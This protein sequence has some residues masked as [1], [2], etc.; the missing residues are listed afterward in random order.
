[1][2]TIKSWSGS[3]PHAREV[4]ALD[5]LRK[6]LPSNWFGYANVFVK[7]P[8]SDTG[9]EVDLI[10]ISDDRILMIDVKD[11]VGKISYNRG[12]W[13]QEVSDRKQRTM[14]RDPVLKLIDA[15]NALI[16]SMR[17]ARIN[18][19]PF[20][21]KAVVFARSTTDFSE[22]AEIHKKG[23][24]GRVLDV[25]T[26][27]SNSKNTRRLD[28]VI[29]KPAFKSAPT[30][31]TN[32][33][34]DLYRKLKGFFQ[35][36]RHF[37]VAE[38][39]YSAYRAKNDEVFST[40]LWAHYEATSKDAHD[41]LAL[42]RRWNFDAEVGVT[43]VD[44]DRDTLV[45]R[46]NNIQAFLRS[47][48]TGRDTPLLAFKESSNTGGALRW[49]LF[50][51]HPDN[52]VLQR[53][54]PRTRSEVSNHTRIALLEALMEAGSSLAAAEVAHRDIGEHSVWLDLERQ[55][56]SLSNLVTAR[57]PETKTT[58]RNLAWL[59]HSRLVDP[60]TEDS[61]EA[62]A[63]DPFRADV[64]AFAYA[65]LK[66]LLG[67]LAKNELDDEC[68][69]YAV[70]EEAK[71]EAGIGPALDSWF[72][73][74]L[75]ANPRERFD[76][77]IEAHSALL[78][79][80]LQDRED[81]PID[82]LEP[83]R[84]QEPCM[85]AYPI[86]ESLSTTR[87]GVTE[88]RS[89]L[90]SGAMLRARLWNVSNAQD[91][92]SAILDFV[93]RG[94]SLSVLPPTIAPRIV[95]CS[96][97]AYG[98]FLC[99]EETIGDRL[100]DC[101][102]YIRDLDQDGLVDLCR[103][104]AKAVL[105]AHDLDLAHGDLSPSNLLFA[106]QSGG[107]DSED[108]DVAVRIIDWLD[109][110]TNEAGPRETVAY[111]GDEPDPMQR[112]RRALGRIIL[113]LVKNCAA[114]SDIIEAAEIFAAE[115]PQDAGLSWRE[116]SLLDVDELLSTKI[117]EEARIAV[118]IKDMLNGQIISPEDGGYR[119]LFDKIDGSTGRDPSARSVKI[120]GLNAVV[121][122]SF[123]ATTKNFR[124]AQSRR[125]SNRLEQFASRKGHRIELTLVSDASANSNCWNF[126]RELPGFDEMFPESPDLQ[127]RRRRPIL[128][129]SSRKEPEVQ[130]QS[131]E[132]AMPSPLR[133]WDAMLDAEATTWPSATAL[134]EAKRMASRP[135]VY[136]VEVD[137]A[138][139]PNLLEPGLLVTANDRTVAKLEK[140]R[141][142][143]GVIEIVSDRGPPS[144]IKPNVPMEFI[145]IG[146]RSNIRRRQTALRKI[147]DA[148]KIVS[149]ERYFSD[150]A[151]ATLGESLELGREPLDYS[152][153]EP[154]SRALTKLWQRGPV[155]FLQGPPGTGKTMFIAAFIHHALTHGGAKNV[156]LT[157]QTHEA[158]DGAAARLLELFQNRGEE[159]DLIRIASNAERID[160]ALRNAHAAAL[161]ERV[162]QRF[163]AERAERVVALATP[164]GIEPEFVRECSK[165]LR[166][167]VA[168]AETVEALKSQIEGSGVAE[169]AE[170]EMLKRMKGVLE[171]QCASYG[172][173]PELGQNPLAL[174]FRLFEDAAKRH[175][176]K[177]ADASRLILRL[178]EAANEYEEALGQRGA[179]EPVFVRTR[180]LVCGTCV[181]LGDEKLGLI[182]EAFDLVVVD[183]AAR[184]QGSELAI[185]LVTGRKVLLVGDQK[186]LEPFLDREALQKAAKELGL[187]EAQLMRSDFE[188]AFGSP[189]GETAS[190]LLDIQYR[191]APT[192]GGMVSDVFY[193][194]KLKTGRGAPQ[195]EWRALPWP[196][197]SE[198]SW[199]SSSGK[200]TARSGRVSNDSEVE[201][202][203]ESLERLAGSDQG[204]SL[205]D[206]HLCAQKSELFVGVIAMYAEQVAAIQRRIG[207]SSLDR[208]WRDQ[209]K[210]G[211][212]DS[213]QGKENPIVMVSLVRDNSKKNIGFLRTENRINVALSRAKERLVIFGSQRMF[214]GSDSKLAQ[215]L[216]HPCLKGRIGPIKHDDFVVN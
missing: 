184:A 130:G 111:G 160:G 199:V 169:P 57:A 76:N 67:P 78:K 140:V 108:E 109:F 5:E 83:H 139:E 208:N 181:G 46:E 15:G 84:R 26:L 64:H 35:V 124:L 6:G 30:G 162:R 72:E 112:D 88:W 164:L 27:T 198:I 21:M 176:V 59:A 91:Q 156:L 40:D 144:I 20:V 7:D 115:S 195:P 16:T 214:S 10:L 61:K 63:L 2:A 13:C 175:R 183:E 113:E 101:N 212:V 48:K 103:S 168:T 207:T 154:Q 89:K 94:K 14:G 80:L 70:N 197:D 102:D 81:D 65:G 51:N 180:R 210:V 32:K 77:C 11:W 196:F 133:V 193:D 171:R 66:I 186:Q 43:I 95:E 97:D 49:E 131:P 174:R 85:M 8:R 33:N 188:R 121:E 39:D 3:S 151:P 31:L 60:A 211:T 106:K 25:A 190:A 202:I 44:A 166:S 209:I 170:A 135:G 73:T 143:E 34:S 178:F 75:S 172:V 206:N 132:P 213:Y 93:R 104:V 45:G 189:Y 194:G 127:K 37:S 179:L 182:D 145:D 12:Q 136:R 177:R 187:E 126:V 24:K 28:E 163:S 157:A 110:S 129:I 41:D 137:F 19:V 79:A 203:V 153:N 98:P 159:I 42:L 125:S 18:P 107:G 185:P 148:P 204:R 167:V 47:H 150:R 69:F 122:V 74:A 105:I 149:L 54:L 56:V 147:L 1:M 138:T 62:D 36:G 128:S 82:L 29:G 117:E 92:A 90:G 201:D 17:S 155:S 58:A 22:V 120:V 146:E 119:V 86:H 158:V 68:A 191:M 216:A 71:T 161:Q 116:V 215:V 205:L 4:A 23:G 100:S 141:G 96:L 52:V 87:P 99:V 134:S 142:S 173:E 165:I 152:L 50:Q 118:P 55:S 9:Y 123:D 38:M 53:F 200:E 192:I 114:A